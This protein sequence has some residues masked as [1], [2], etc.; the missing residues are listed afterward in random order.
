MGLLRKRKNAEGQDDTSNTIATS[1]IDDETNSEVQEVM[2]DNLELM[3]D[4]VMRIRE[5]PDFAK[6][7]YKDC[8]RLQHLLDQYPDLR[9]I[10]EDPKLVRI[11]F[12]QVY[13]DAGGVLPEDE[14]KAKKKSWLV[15]LVNSP[16]FKVLKLLLFVKKLMACIAGGGFA[17]LAGCLMGCCFEDAL[18]ELDGDADADADAD[19]EDG[20]IDPSKEALNRAADHMEDPEVQEHMQQLLD[21]PEGLDEAVE[22]DSE[23]RALRDSNPLCGELMSDPD[24]M[25]ILTDPD[26]LRALGEAPD[27]IEA[28]FIDPEGFAPTDIETGGAF[29]GIEGGY[30]GFDG[31]LDQDFD[32]DIEADDDGFDNNDD[33]DA[34]GE[35]EEEEE[36]EEGWW[37]DAELEEQDGPDDQQGGAKGG[38]KGQAKAQP[39]AQAKQAQQQG[40]AVDDAPKGR[41]GGVMAM[42]G[43]A[44]ADL[45]AGQLVGSVFGDGLVPGGMGGGGG[46][47]DGL[48]DAGGDDIG[49]AMDDGGIND[50]ADDAGDMADNAGDVADVAED[51]MDEVDDKADGAKGG[52]DAADNDPDA[53]DTDKDGK[54]GKKG[55]AIAGGVAGGAVVGG[56]AGV[57]L[58]GSKDRKAVGEDGEELE[59]GEDTFADEEGVAAPKKSKLGWMKSMAASVVTAT[60]EHITTSILG[61]DFG[62]QVVEWHEE[63][64]DEDKKEEDD[65]ENDNKKKDEE[66]E[67]KKKRGMFGRKKK[68]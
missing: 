6:N 5:E 62:E 46:D 26:N 53:P 66:V 25:R 22:N 40:G 61:D 64:K 16:I 4:V 60:K 7:I 29:E 44:A 11:N 42:V 14:E 19:M 18:E 17:F 38:Q 54:D 21:D 1:S 34:E 55:A 27:L 41:F 33:F 8:P 56:A 28:D 36:E 43:V 15:W 24:T 67:K 65:E 52:N 50:M 49:T 23:L 51:T 37:D 39:K 3:K 12:E 10:F 63:E 32:I 31:G 35:E 48:D 45:I 13:R 68:D 58:S 9:P 2:K 20:Q 59:E 57:A 47:L 30:D